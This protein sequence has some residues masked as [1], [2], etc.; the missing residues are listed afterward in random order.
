MSIKVNQIKVGNYY[1]AGDDCNQLRK[2]I[3]IKQD[4][5]NRNLIVYVSKSANIPGC[6][7]APAATLANPALESTFA[8]ACCKELSASEI[9]TLRQNNIILPNE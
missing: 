5:Q 8:K 9:Q 7:F 6:S 2:V 4:T 3:E 1:Y